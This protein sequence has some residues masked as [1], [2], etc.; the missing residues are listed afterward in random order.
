MLWCMEPHG[1]RMSAR[2]R[3]R[4]DIYRHIWATQGTTRPA[5]A[6]VTGLSPSTVGS[7]VGWLL[8]NGRIVE[9]KQEDKGPGSGSG[10]PATILRPAPSGDA[11]AG[12]DF[13]HSHIRIA[14]APATGEPVEEVSVSVDVDLRAEEALD[15]ATERLR[16]LTA[17]HGIQRL[18]RVVAGIP[19][20]V[21][22]RSGLVRSPTILSSWLG[23]APREELERR[24]GTRVHVE[25]DAVL[26]A[27]GEYRAGAGQRHSD[28][29]YVKVSH[30]I[31]AGLVIG[32][33][34]YHGGTGLAGEIGHT[35]LP[36]RSELC[37]CGRLGCLEA[38]V[39]VESVR[40]QILHSHP[41]QD[42]DFVIAELN[43]FIT[44][45]ILNEAGRTVGRVLADLCNLL[46]PTALII[47]GQL[48]TAGA[49][50]IDGV[51]ASIR[52][53][54]QPA[55]VE[56]LEVSAATLGT[57]AEVLG[58]LELAQVLAQP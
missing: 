27:W 50:L 14:L 29:I 28:F 58:A 2:N 38:A 6:E 52:R 5:L 49:S 53:F 15:V 43:D 56:A 42:A 54:A 24:L 8:A 7:A 45:R 48:G 9:S 21:D 17:A 10:R 34:I 12:I 18:A 46:N 47:G 13:G 44:D 41:R 35:Q 1:E 19:G 31:G 57:R 51:R 37:R 36:G 11:V 23:V 20:P 4:E 26:G 16:A 33:Q 30:G 32:G 22:R 25:N 3:T 40:Q 55:T 39:S